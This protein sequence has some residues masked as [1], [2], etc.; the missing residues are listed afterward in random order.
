MKISLSQ[1]GSKS[2]W[3]LSAVVCI[4]DF[5]FKL[6]STDEFQGFFSPQFL[7]DVISKP[8]QGP[9]LLPP[10]SEKLERLVGTRGKG[11]GFCCPFPSAAS[12][13]DVSKESSNAGS[14]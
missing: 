10:P 11:G 4:T 5:S 12:G 7:D 14:L 1:I 2:H 13:G 8:R 3:K 6:E 9:V